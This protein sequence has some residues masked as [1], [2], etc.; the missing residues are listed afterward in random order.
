MHSP[1]WWRN[2]INMVSLYNN[3][4]TLYFCFNF[5]HFLF[6][7]AHKITAIIWWYYPN[8]GFHTFIRFKVLNTVLIFTFNS[9][10]QFC[11]YINKMFDEILSFLYGSKCDISKWAFSFHNS[12]HVKFWVKKT[13]I[14]LSSEVVINNYIDILYWI[15]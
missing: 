4:Q 11:L 5:P 9:N 7:S 2:N 14:K 8:W 13:L 10:I 3:C 15:L 12:C 6:K 1:L